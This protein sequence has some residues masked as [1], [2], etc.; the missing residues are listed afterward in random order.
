VFNKKENKMRKK[1]DN[2]N[3]GALILLI[4]A[5]LMVYI[6][7]LGFF[8]YFAFPKTLEWS[9]TQKYEVP[10]S[11][12]DFLSWGEPDGMIPIM[13]DKEKKIA[14]IAG[15]KFNPQ[16]PDEYVLVFVL[17]KAAPKSEAHIIAVYYVPSIKSIKDGKGNVLVYCDDSLLKTS[18]PSLRLTLA[19]SE[20]TK[21]QWEA[22]FE[23]LKINKGERI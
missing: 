3:G 14:V 1:K 13:I 17:V 5:I 21:E 9:P 20:I 11:L 4:S 12:P 23:L 16:N 7:S 15:E 22:F 19:S 18:S 6:A 2:K 10:D 8:V